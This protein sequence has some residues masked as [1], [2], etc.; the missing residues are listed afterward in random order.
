MIIN[1]LKFYKTY[2]T[3]IDYKDRTNICMQPEK[4]KK[5]ISHQ[6]TVVDFVEGNKKQ[7]RNPK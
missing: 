1:L 5:N 4:F 2:Q 7:E 6:L 3:I